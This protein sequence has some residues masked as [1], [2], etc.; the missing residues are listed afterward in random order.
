MN[1]FV[2]QSELCVAILRSSLGFDEALE[3]DDILQG[4]GRS[5]ARRDSR[6]MDDSVGQ[7]E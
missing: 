5:E 1:N 7:R 4:N 6:K 2:V 3:R